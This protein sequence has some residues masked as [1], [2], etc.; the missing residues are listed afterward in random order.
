[1]GL[2][3]QSVSFC[4]TGIAMFCT[5][6]VGQVAQNGGKIPRF[7]IVSAIIAESCENGRFPRGEPPPQPKKNQKKSNSQFCLIK[8]F[9]QVLIFKEI[10]S[11]HS[12][13]KCIFSLEFR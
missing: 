12:N 11:L 7:C 13:K 2:E 3:M 4:V 6:G 8:I 10:I 5:G 9:W 1:M